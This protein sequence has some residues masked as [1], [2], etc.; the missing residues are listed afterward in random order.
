MRK[1]INR[2]EMKE[3]IKYLLIIIGLFIVFELI[4]HISSCMF[5]NFRD[6]CFFLSGYM[7]ATIYG[8]VVFYTLESKKDEK[9][10]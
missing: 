3:Y 8:M 7:S 5:P 2:Q 4:A 10:D 1:L 6:S 9:T